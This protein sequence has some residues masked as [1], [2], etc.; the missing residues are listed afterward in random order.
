MRVNNKIK[1]V[2][3]RRDSYD[4]WLSLC[5]RYKIVRHHGALQ[6]KDKNGSRPVRDFIYYALYRPKGWKNFG[7]H[8]NKSNDKGIRYTTL[9]VAKIACQIHLDSGYYEPEPKKAQT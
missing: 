2:T 4:V 8:V 7:N 3:F 5:G 6:Y 1:H 9:P